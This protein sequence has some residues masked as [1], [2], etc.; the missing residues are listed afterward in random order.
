M[1]LICPLK[2][3]LLGKFTPTYKKNS[4]TKHQVNDSNTL[5]KFYSLIGFKT[6]VI[7]IIQSSNGSNGLE[8][9]NW[10]L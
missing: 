10:I 6:K 5:A 2:F 4:T 7:T 8:G 9:V 1:M 3:P